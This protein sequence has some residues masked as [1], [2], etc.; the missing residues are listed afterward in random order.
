MIGGTSTVP[1]LIKKIQLHIYTRTSIVVV[2]RIY[3][4]C[5]PSTGEGVY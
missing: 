4:P 1:T 5:S 2:G 3:I